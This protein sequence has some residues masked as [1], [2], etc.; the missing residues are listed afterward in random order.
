MANNTSKTQYNQDDLVEL[1][2]PVV[3]VLEDI[4]VVPLIGILDSHR[5]QKIMENLLDSVV[6]HRARVAIID[7]TGVPVVDTMTAAHL[8]NTTK[9]VRLLGAEAIITGIS[10]R[11]AQIIVEM[12][13]DLSGVITY[14]V[15]SEGVIAALKMLNKKI[16]S[17]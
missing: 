14:S 4:L 3:P 8:M 9:A 11:I 12:G 1:V 13:I 15:M 17:V 10:A 7:I 2:S 6:K 5:T 16:V